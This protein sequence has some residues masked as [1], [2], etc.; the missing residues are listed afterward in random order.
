MTG[1]QADLAHSA[2]A[3][4]WQR[5]P[6]VDFSVTYMCQI[7]RGV[8]RVSWIGVAGRT[9]D[10]LDRAFETVHGGIV[11]GDAPAGPLKQE[12]AWIK[13]LTGGALVRLAEARENAG[14]A[15]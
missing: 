6:I 5:L 1:E 7:C 3:H 9:L 12:A 15:P 2:C 14:G 8:L 13:H 11:T 10:D 4:R